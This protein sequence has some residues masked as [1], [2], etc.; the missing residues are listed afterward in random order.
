[1]KKQRIC[2]VGDGLSGLITALAL[3]NLSSLDV[4]LITKKNKRGK[5]KRT[6]AIS[7]SNYQFLREILKKQ[8]KKLF[9]P[10]KTINLFYETND[11]KINFLNFKEDKNKLMYVFENDKIKKVLRKEIKK[12]KIKIIK[13]NIN[14]LSDLNGYD[15]KALCLGPNSKIYQSVVDS[16]SIV[17]DYKEVSITGYVK[18]NLKNINTSQFFLKEGPL[19][20]LP[21]A[22]N[23]FSFVWS[24]KKKFIQKNIKFI[25][26]S[27]ISELLKIN[28]KINV[29]N[30]Q[31]YPLTLNLKRTYYKNDTLILGEGLHTIHPL[32]G[33]GFNLVMRDIKK[34]KEVL[35]YYT[36]LGISIKSSLALDDFSS[37]RKSENIIT[38]LG[39]DLTHI[40]FKQNKLL[41]PLKEIILKNVSRNN[42]LKKISKFISN[43]GLSI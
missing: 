16:R 29:N 30:I 22:N 17:K 12:K 13:K 43:Q 4:H 19:A 35:K 15:F 36:S 34:L 14:K 6:T 3:N 10:S 24:I 18:H 39:I 41:E 7:A 8:N 5:D 37:S 9:W 32:A 38:G 23:K 26:K 21:F 27:K 28:K 42:T 20:I 40:F 31:S 25:I 2:I 33:Q 11:Q 1:M